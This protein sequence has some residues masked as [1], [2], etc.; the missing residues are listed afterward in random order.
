MS[1][2]GWLLPSP[3]NAITAF[4]EFSGAKEFGHGLPSPTPPDLNCTSKTDS[5]LFLFA[6]RNTSA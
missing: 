4:P 6:A 1:N 2:D 3:P 5:L